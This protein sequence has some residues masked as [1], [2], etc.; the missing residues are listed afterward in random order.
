MSWYAFFRLLS[1]GMARVVSR[2]EVEG[3]HHVPPDG[4]FILVPN[5]QSVLDPIFVQ[6][7]VPRPDIYTLTKSTQFGS[8]V[9]RWLLPRVQAI[10]VRRFRV[11]PQAVRVLLRRLDE[12]KGVCVYPEGERTWDGSVGP[13]RRGA[14]RVILK[15][16]VPVVP[17]GVSGSFAIWPRWSRSI[18]RSTVRV[19]FGE[20]LRFGRWDDR[21]ERNARVEETA[22]AIR[23]ALLALSG[24]PP[25]RPEEPRPERPRF[26]EAASPPAGEGEQA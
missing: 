8:G 3:R 23:D 13:L 21:R 6:V 18:R 19:R 22:A 26:E 20:P 14:V 7:S 24:A 17:C 5:H 4:P 15:A 10:P 25:A 1:A 9:F 12:G 16:G 2:M 11:D